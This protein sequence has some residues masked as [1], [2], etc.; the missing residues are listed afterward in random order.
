MSRQRTRAKPFL[1]SLLALAL[2]AA[3]CAAAASAARPGESEPAGNY[4]QWPDD[5]VFV[6]A[7]FLKESPGAA[8][9][10]VYAVGSDLLSVTEL[11]KVPRVVT[12]GQSEAVAAVGGR[13]L[14]AANETVVQAHRTA[15]DALE[16]MVYKKA[17]APAT[18]A[19]LAPRVAGCSDF[20]DMAAGDLDG[21]LW[22]WERRD[23]V[24]VA[25]TPASAD[26]KLPVQVAVL[27]YGQVSDARPLPPVV[28]QATGSAAVNAAGIGATGIKPQDNVLAVTTG[29]FD[30]NRLQEIAVAYLSGPSRLTVDVFRYATFG[31]GTS[32]THNL[33]RIGTGFADIPA[34]ASPAKS[35][36]VAALSATSGDFNGDGRDE[37]ALGTANY[38]AADMDEHVRVFQF[39]GTSA[40]T[41]SPSTVTDLRTGVALGTTGRV[42]VAAGLFRFDPGAGFGLNRRQLAVAYSHL[43]NVVLRTIEYGTDL[44]A[45]LNAPLT[46][47]SR[48]TVF[49]LVAGRLQGALTAASSDPSWSLGLTGWEPRLTASADPRWCFAVFRAT[50]QATPGRGAPE[51]GGAVWKP[52]ASDPAEG[53]RLALATFDRDGDSILLGAPVHFTV[54]NLITTD[55]IL[56]EPP[57][58]MCWDPVAGEVKNVSRFDDFS[59]TLDSA[60]KQTAQVSSK[61]HASSALG[62]SSELSF[63]AKIGFSVPIDI[64]KIG[65]DISTDYTRT[66]G[67]EYESNSAGY[68]T[69]YSEQS[70]AF[71]AS[72]TRD[73]YIIGKLRKVDIWRYRIFGIASPLADTQPFMDFVMPAASNEL[74]LEEGGLDEAAYQPVHENGNI[75]SYPRYSSTL[76]VD[77]GSYTLPDES[78][79]KGLLFGNVAYVMGGI[80]GSRSL[81]WTTASGAGSERSYTQTLSESSSL[82]TS[83][84]VSVE[85]GPVN[86]GGSSSY[87]FSRNDKNSWGNVSTDDATLSNSVGFTL[88]RPAGE[89]DKAYVFYPTV[90][91]GNDGTIK[92]TFAVNPLGSDTGRVWWLREYGQKPDLALNLPRR[93]TYSADAGKWI[94][95]TSDVRKKMRGLFVQQ[96]NEDTGEYYDAPAGPDDA[97]CGVVGSGV[98]GRLQARVY[99]YSVDNGGVTNVPAGAKVRFSLIEYDSATRTEIGERT[100]IGETILSEPLLPQGMATVSLDWTAPA[101]PPGVFTKA[102]RIYVELD[103]DNQVAEKYETEAAG[104]LDPGQNNEGYGAIRVIY[105]G[106]QAGGSG[107]VAH[108]GIARKGVAMTNLRGRLATGTVRAYQGRTVRVRVKVTASERTANTHLVLLFDRRPGKPQVLIGKQRVFLGDAAG[109]NAWFT[110][111][112]TKKGSHTLF[113]KVLQAANDPKPGGNTGKVAVKVVKAPRPK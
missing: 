78:P 60:E 56:Q 74:R 43:D 91:M 101:L 102:Y 97:S 112:P 104:T 12:A 105:P 64:V 99:N 13:I 51:P 35:Q 33:K 5:E 16:V 30:G 52:A 100:M 45:K 25:Y 62:A 10:L 85:I 57:K 71:A 8:F 67:E 79:F 53:S 88:V 89:G 28:T 27:D 49:A 39:G 84:N 107:P 111:R 37:L 86:F 92:A 58:H 65:A 31:S 70:V 7:P 94:V 82:K 32:V 14:S 23:E 76:P 2:L 75:L 68:N 50:A 24:V 110:W 72:T 90:Y 61:G 55:Y 1:A 44:A 69:M 26:S 106:R 21:F 6:T 20:F 108:V 47:Q 59:I 18:L 38:V 73:D 54:E 19:N 96:I 36:W 3:V 103:P 81:Q 48:A 42:R 11:E 34:L 95:Q 41:V 17:Y 63:G 83:A 4:S 113:A 80:S 66:I 109:V 93:F 40:L 77:L 98:A 87:A 29:D 22:A 46:T 9:S 15:A